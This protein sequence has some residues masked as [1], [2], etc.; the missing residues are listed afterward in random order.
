MGL[1]QQQN[2]FRSALIAYP[3]QSQ[4]NC[5]RANGSLALSV[6]W[7]ANHTHGE[8]SHCGLPIENHDN[9]GTSW[10]QNT[11]GP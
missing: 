6:P 9:Q 3:I 8:Q 4:V 2:S 5:V 11:V 10:D 1:F 7:W